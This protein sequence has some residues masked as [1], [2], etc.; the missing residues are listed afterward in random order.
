MKCPFCGFNNLAGEDLCE[1]CGESLTNF[2]GARPRDRLEKSIVKDAIEKIETPGMAT[3]AP[4]AS[5]KEVVEQLARHNR[6]ILVTEGDQLVGI[7]TE[8]DVLFKFMG[9]AKNAET[10]PV[11]QIMTAKPET[12]E[13]SDKIALALNKMTIGGFR[14][15]P[16]T[17]Q[18][19]PQ[20]VVSVRD[21]IGYLA[22]MFP[23]LTRTKS[24]DPASSPKL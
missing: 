7:V 2:E 11:S 4:N 8:R 22:D 13:P 24:V 1:H 9:S 10:T 12:L 16:I 5:V 21:V 18:G 17:R 6:C 20:G 15:I 19:V 23:E 3:V 14:H